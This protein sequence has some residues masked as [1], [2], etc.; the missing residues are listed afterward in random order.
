VGLDIDGVLADFLTPFLQL[1]EREAGSGPIPP[2][3]VTDFTFKQHPCLGEAT[4]RKCLEDVSNNA[5]FWLDLKPLITVSEWEKLD[6][7]SYGDRLVFIT[8]RCEGD[9]YRMA[10]IS[11]EWLRKHGIRNPVVHL[12]REPKARLIQDLDVSLFV[13]D[14]HENCEDAAT[15]TVATVLMPDRSYNQSFCHPRVKRIWSFAELFAHLDE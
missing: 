4:V 15:R 10:D 8:H 1:L 12:T 2:Q 13:D 6:Q 9:S 11:R 14:R 3:S 5:A 7:L